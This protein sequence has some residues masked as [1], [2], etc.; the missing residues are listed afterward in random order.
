MNQ[1][2]R[3][4]QTSSKNKNYGSDRTSGYLPDVY[5]DF[6]LRFPDVSQAI[7][8]VA[9]KCHAAGPLDKKTSELIKLGMAVGIN[10]EGA[11]RSHARRAMRM[12]ISKDEIRHVVLLAFTTCGFPHTIAAF[13][14]VEEVLAKSEYNLENEDD[15]S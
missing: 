10:S 13:K 6:V 7:D 15:K 12:G 9:Q 4:T 8:V 5:K 14:W 3:K 11:I 2:P 1:M